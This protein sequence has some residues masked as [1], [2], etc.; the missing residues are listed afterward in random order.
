M[1]TVFRGTGS[2]E[3]QGSAAA[4]TFL[5]GFKVYSECS[6]LGLKFRVRVV[7]SWLDASDAE[8]EVCHIAASPQ[9]QA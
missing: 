7:G 5:A 8:W 9:W 2:G 4:G 1:D 6:G 3:S